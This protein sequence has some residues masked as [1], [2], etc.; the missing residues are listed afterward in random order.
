MA[1]HYP[2]VDS[3]L[4]GAQTIALLFL[5]YLLGLYLS[6]APVTW[7]IG[8][9]LYGIALT[10]LT[11]SIYN[12]IKEI[13]K[14][15][16]LKRLFTFIGIN[17]FAMYMINQPFIQEYF[18][19]VTEFIFPYRILFFGNR[20]YIFK[21]MLYQHLRFQNEIHGVINNMYIL[22]ISTYLLILTSYAILI[23]S[24]SFVLTKIYGKCLKLAR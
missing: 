15:H 8:R 14:L 13:K 23:I 9:P 4:R 11:W 18:F 10:L 21:T 1:N 12:M 5:A 24:L 2:K 17:S 16:V 7:P 6:S 19:S 22:P 3:M 20:I